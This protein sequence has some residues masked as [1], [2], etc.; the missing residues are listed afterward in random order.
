M[1]TFQLKHEYVYYNVVSRSVYFV[2]DFSQLR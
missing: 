1:L 2:H